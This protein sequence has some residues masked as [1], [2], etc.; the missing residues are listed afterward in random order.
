MENCSITVTI[1]ALTSPYIK[2]FSP[3]FGSLGSSSPSNVH[4]EIYALDTTSK[5]DLGKLSWRT[6]PARSTHLGTLVAT[7]NTT[8]E[9]SAAFECKRATY[10]TI[11]VVCAAEDEDCVVD[12]VNAAPEAVGEFFPKS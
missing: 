3:S 1:P 6:K 5:L 7:P 2:S 4:L 8:I 10:V 9:L 11:E 12:V